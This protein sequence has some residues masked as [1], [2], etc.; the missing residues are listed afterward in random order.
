V[1]GGEAWEIV[2]Q[3]TVF[4]FVQAEQGRDCEEHV[5]WGQRGVRE[6]YHE[7]LRRMVV[8]LVRGRLMMFDWL[9]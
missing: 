5:R 6:P 9:D 4:G 8:G 1:P 7:H 3:D 2:P